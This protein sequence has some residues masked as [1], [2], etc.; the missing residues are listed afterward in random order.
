MCKD[1]ATAAT[2]A[3]GFRGGFRGNRQRPSGSGSL[4]VASWHSEAIQEALQGP[5]ASWPQQGT[6]GGCAYEIK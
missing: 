5:D 4:P 6:A 3:Q 1:E 2:Q